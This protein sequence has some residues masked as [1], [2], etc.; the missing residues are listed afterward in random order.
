MEICNPSQYFVAAATSLSIHD[1]SHNT[2][3]FGWTAIQDTANTCR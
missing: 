3:F 1:H 2:R